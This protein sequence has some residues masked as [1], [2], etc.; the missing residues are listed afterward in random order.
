MSLLSNAQ[1]GRP[2]ASSFVSTFSLP[3][4]AP[5]ENAFNKIIRRVFES[6][7]EILDHVLYKEASGWMSSRSDGIHVLDLLDFR[8][9]AVFWLGGLIGSCISV[10]LELMTHSR[11]K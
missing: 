11:L 1:I 4:W 6:K 5:Y 10:S 8:L 7:L 3:P 9:I 2:I